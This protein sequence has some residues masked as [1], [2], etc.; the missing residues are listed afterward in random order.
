MT[1]LR[2]RYY[3]VQSAGLIDHRGARVSVAFARQLSWASAL[4]Y[5]SDGDVDTFRAST[6]LGVVT[7]RP[8]ICFL[9]CLL[10][11]A[12]GLLPS[13]SSP[14]GSGLKRTELTP[15]PRFP[16]DRRQGL[17]LRP[18]MTLQSQAA[19]SDC[20]AAR[21]RCHPDLAQRLFNCHHC[22]TRATVC[23]TCDRGQQYCSA[24]CRQQQRARQVREAGQR[25]QLRE[26]G[27]LLH[28]ARQ[29]AYQASRKVPGAPQPQARRIASAAALP[30]APQAG[31]PPEPPRLPIRSAQTPAGLSSTEPCC[32]CCGRRSY[33]LLRQTS[34]RRRQRRAARRA[35]ALQAGRSGA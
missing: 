15:R 2:T 34:L 11:D 19:P 24:A 30:P 21:P 23:T 3:P 8:G 13:L 9:L 29:R 6:S 20:V 10:A 17:V 35:R 26:P 22:N 5:A 4:C 31:R 32:C 1:A 7:L 14:W 16:V 12:S 18:C 28:A 27:R 25:Y 33:L